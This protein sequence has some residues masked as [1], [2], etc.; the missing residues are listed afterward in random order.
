MIGILNIPWWKRTNLDRTTQV[1][2]GSSPNRLNIYLIDLV[3]LVDAAMGLTFLL[4]SC[5]TLT[6]FLLKVVLLPLC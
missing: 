2:S 6:D 3:L 4:L 5:K 1:V